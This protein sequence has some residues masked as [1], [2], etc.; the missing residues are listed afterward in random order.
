MNTCPICGSSESAEL[1]RF[2]LARWI[3]STVVRCNACGTIYKVPFD[4][5]KPLASYYDEAYAGLLDWEH[6]DI[7]ALPVF[8]HIRDLMTA[9]LKGSGRALLDVGCGPGNFLHLAQ[10]AGFQVTGLELNPI[11]ANRARSRTGAEVIQ[12][13]F[14]STELQGRRFDVVTMLDLIEHLQDP[15]GAL[16]QCRCLLKPGGSLILYTPNHSSLIVLI[17]QAGYRLSGAR[18]SGPVAEIFDCTHVTFFDV[19]TLGLAVTKAGFGIA[20]TIMSRYDPSRTKQAKGFQASVL[21]AVEA[22]SPLVRGQFRILMI[23][24]NPH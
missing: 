20:K 13:D 22:V 6:D 12:G 15:V 5:A 1:Y 18:W 24:R 10:E 2:E 19:R 23:V 7:G 9:E 17:A 21:K 14:L 8:T 16:K 11:L 4:L 3:P